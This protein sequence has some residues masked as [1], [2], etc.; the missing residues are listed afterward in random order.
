MLTAWHELCPSNRAVLGHR[1]LLH[2]PGRGSDKEFCCFCFYCLVKVSTQPA[3]QLFT[4][5]RCLTRQV[6]MSMSRKKKLVQDTASHHV[7]RT[8]SARTCSLL[9]HVQRDLAARQWM[10]FS[11]DDYS[12][13][14]FPFSLPSFAAL[15]DALHFYPVT[16]SRR[17]VEDLNTSDR[18]RPLCVSRADVIAINESRETETERE[19][20]EGKTDKRER[21]YMHSSLHLFA[22]INAHNK[23]F[24]L[25]MR[26]QGIA[27]HLHLQRK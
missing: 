5:F 24:K 20:R 6:S 19:K 17:L 8:K 2:H 11:G 3:G 10:A 1:S 23:L 27:A 12:V 18:S 9:L 25:L 14:F 4:K 7:M 21:L 15:E 26:M 22:T 16:C 13:F